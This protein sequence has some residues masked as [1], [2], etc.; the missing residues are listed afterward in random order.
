MRTLTPAAVA[1]ILS[2]ISVPASADTWEDP[3]PRPIEEDGCKRCPKKPAPVAPPPAP[4]PDAGVPVVVNPPPPAPAPPPFEFAPVAP[5]ATTGNPGFV[6]G[7]LS[8]GVIPGLWVMPAQVIDENAYPNLSG[9]DAF[10]GGY[11][12]LGG[13]KEKAAY[14]DLHAAYGRGAVGSELISVGAMVG[15]ALKSLD[16]HRVIAG[17]MLDGGIRDYDVVEGDYMAR[18]RGALGGP[19]LIVELDKD[20]DLLDVALA[21]AALVGWAD[22]RH[23][24]NDDA[25]L[26]GFEMGAKIE[27]RVGLQGPR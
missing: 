14:L 7:G 15:V 23:A 9:F 24:L 21:G 12:G 10:V 25:D 5:P 3:D 16:E 22:V 13:H 17:V 18:R 6:R 26:S 2:L 4:V 19:Q 8:V 27:L 1:A 20:K 11:F